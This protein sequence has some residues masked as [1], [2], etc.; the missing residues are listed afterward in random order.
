[1]V[2]HL[3]K[4]G[5]ELSEK[6]GK[7]SFVSIDDGTNKITSDETDIKIDFLSTETAR[8]YIT[9]NLTKEY[10]ISELSDIHKAL[11]DLILATPPGTSIFL[12][13]SNLSGT[14]NNVEINSDNLFDTINQIASKSKKSTNELL[15][16]TFKVIEHHDSIEQ[17]PRF[18]LSIHDESKLK[19]RLANKANELYTPIHMYII[20]KNGLTKEEETNI[21]RLTENTTGTYKLGDVTSF[22]DYVYTFSLYLV[23]STFVVKWHSTYTSNIDELEIVVTFNYMDKE[24]TIKFNMA[25]V[26]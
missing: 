26:S 18:I 15:V 10:S 17:L 23:Q 21:K 25:L 5:L 22:I 24:Y 4:F 12:T 3:T 19:A 14:I 13:Y 16:E 11:T 7:P 2:L 9:I 1:M 6:L 20:N 8:I